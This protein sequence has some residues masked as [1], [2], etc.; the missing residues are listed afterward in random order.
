M[1]T[2]KIFKN[3][4]I[5]DFLIM[6]FGIV[7]VSLGISW[8]AVEEPNSNLYSDLIG[9]IALILIIVYYVNLLLL[10]KFKPIARPLYFVITVLSILM[11][12]FMSVEDLTL[13]QL[14]AS[15]DEVSTILSGVI[16]ALIYFSDIKEKFKN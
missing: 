10:Y 16:L 9:F 6:S 4:L 8:D 13:N 14:E 11:N 12:F 1:N 7:Y 15:I 3:I 5:L 2:E